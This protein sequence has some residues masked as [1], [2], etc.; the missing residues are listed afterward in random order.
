MGFGIRSAKKTYVA[1]P[2]AKPAGLSKFA[3]APNPHVEPLKTRIYTKSVLRQDPASF[4]DFGFG[5]GLGSPSM[6][7]MSRKPR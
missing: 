2:K 4:G 6:L 5:D 3:H 7:G 1:A